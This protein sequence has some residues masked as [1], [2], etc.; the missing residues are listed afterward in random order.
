MK[1]LQILLPLYDQSG[2]PFASSI[3]EQ[4]KSE[5]TIRFGGLTA[6]T[7]SPASGTWKKDGEPI[8]KDEIYVYEVMT[9]EV[10]QQF[11]KT[12]KNNLQQLFEQNELIVRVSEIELL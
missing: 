2:K 7:R 3:Y 5:L 11:W 9:Q 8:V 12:Y 1:L 4:V 6:Y 10:D